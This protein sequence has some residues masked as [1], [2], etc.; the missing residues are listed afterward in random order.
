MNN[1]EFTMVR[2]I[3]ESPAGVHL[4]RIYLQVSIG[5]AV[6]ALVAYL[7]FHL[8]GIR[9]VFFRPDHDLTIA[10]TSVSLLPFLLILVFS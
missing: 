2:D 4:G 8:P 3:P 10:G 6:S 9:D 1:N 7:A 5:L